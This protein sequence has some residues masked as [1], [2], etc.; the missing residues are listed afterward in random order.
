LAVGGRVR[1][2]EAGGGNVA[3]LDFAIKTARPSDLIL[4]Q[5]DRVEQT[6]DLVRRYQATQAA[7]AAHEYHEATGFPRA[8]RTPA[9]SGAAV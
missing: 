1:E 6:I 3:A 5:V 8:V 7:E 9:P 4:V 2:V